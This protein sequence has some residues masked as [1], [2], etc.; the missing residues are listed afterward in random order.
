MPHMYVDAE[1]FMDYGGVQ[2][3]HIYKDDDIEQG[4]RSFWYS[5]EVNGADHEAHGENGTF[6]VR[7]LST[8]PEGAVDGFTVVRQAIRDAIDK[9]ELPMEET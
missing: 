4:A 6:D 3:F 9:G 7:C 5:T 2:I 8:W 1:L